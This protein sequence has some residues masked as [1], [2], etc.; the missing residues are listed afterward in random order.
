MNT[1]IGCQIPGASQPKE[2]VRLIDANNV[3]EAVFCAVELYNSEY[4][5]I[6]DEIKKI[7]TI[8]PESMRPTAHW[9]ECDLVMHNYDDGVDI[10]YRRLGRKCSRCARIYDATKMYIE[11]NYC[12]HCGARIR[13]VSSD[14]S[15]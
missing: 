6:Q 8:D 15:L 11:T 2:P 12:P 1:T 7:P 13:T 14:E 4:L 5:A 10:I 3:M 9:I